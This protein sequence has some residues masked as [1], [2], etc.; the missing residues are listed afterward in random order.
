ML[1]V[2][3]KPLAAASLALALL[4]AAISAPL[5]FS[6]PQKMWITNLVWPVTALYWGPVALWG[7]WKMGAPATSPGRA[8]A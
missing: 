2:W 7:L 6:R 8:G 3:L 5:L 4:C 1:P